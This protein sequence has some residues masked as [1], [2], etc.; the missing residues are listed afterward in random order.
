M[1][2]FHLQPLS[3]RRNQNTSGYLDSGLCHCEKTKSV[4]INNTMCRRGQGIK[5]ISGRS[6]TDEGRHCCHNKSHHNQRFGTTCHM[7]RS[8]DIPRVSADA[9]LTSGVIIEQQRVNLYRGCMVSLRKEWWD[10]EVMSCDI[11]YLSI[12]LSVCQSFSRLAD[13][14]H[15]KTNR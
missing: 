14:G 7:T 1:C 2:V 15:T 8:H 6:F 4:D 11:I 3:L 10:C 12:L 5:A 9:N 13:Q